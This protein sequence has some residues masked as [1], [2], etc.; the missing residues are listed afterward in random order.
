MQF[1]LGAH[2]P[3]WLAR[4]TVPL[5]VS[6][7]RLEGRRTLPRAS[8]DWALDSGGF[9]ELS[10]HG[11]W[12]VSPEEYVAEVRRYRDEIGRMQWAA[13]QD[14]MC[15]PWII[16]KTGLSVDEHQRRTVENYERMLDLAPE[17]PWCP[18]IQGWS[19][20]SYLR[21]LDLYRERGHRLEELPIVGVGSICRRQATTSAYVALGLLH[22]EGL[23]LHGFGF[24]KD[25]LRAAHGRLESADSM[26]WSFNARRNHNHC[27]GCTK[28]GCGNCLDAALWW[29]DELLAQLDGQA[30][31]A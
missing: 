5:F 31:A 1:F 30:V 4:S 28:K 20:W 25:G 27:Q 11:R 21:H 18:V 17:V 24:K 7:V 9:S 12:R 26:A 29:R 2:Q 23:T 6:R 22:A 10:A 15:E 3:D 8:C 19:V 14:W 16:E 13:I